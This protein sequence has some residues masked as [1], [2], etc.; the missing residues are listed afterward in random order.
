MQVQG[1]NIFSG[2]R[3]LGAA[4]T[5]PTELARQKGGLD[6]A[7][8]VLFAGRQ[9]VDVETAYH[10][11][12]AQRGSP[13]QRDQLMVELIAAKFTQHPELYREVS[14]RGGEAFLRECSHFTGARTAG[15]QS[16]EGH[17]LQSRFIRNL[18]AGFAAASSSQPATELG[19]TSLF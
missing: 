12:G 15:A 9:W 4:L 1:I 5:N 16:W 11:L 18:V 13:E 2:E 7:Y 10:V 3:G 8:G 19:Q 14:E 6:Q 17:G